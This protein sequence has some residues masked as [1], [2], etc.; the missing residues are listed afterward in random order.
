MLEPEEND[1]VDLM[2]DFNKP[3]HMLR[4]GVDRLGIDQVTGHPRQNEDDLNRRRNSQFSLRTGP[5]MTPPTSVIV[6][7]V[8]PPR[9]IPPWL[10]MA[11][12]LFLAFCG[13]NDA[14][15]GKPNVT[16]PF[17]CFTR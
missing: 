11:I 6:Q 2:S 5:R 7:P 8:R 14:V 15:C 10:P 4:S 16:Q 9:S 13:A 12:W 3:S 17:A 1:D